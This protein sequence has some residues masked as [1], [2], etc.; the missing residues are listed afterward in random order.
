M[1]LNIDKRKWNLFF[2][3]VVKL[4]IT[5]NRSSLVFGFDLDLHFFKTRNQAKLQSHIQVPSSL[6]LWTSLPTQ[7]LTSIPFFK[8]M[9]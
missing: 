2:S 4:A 1:E 3:E 5:V 9:L 6:S 8:I 7:I